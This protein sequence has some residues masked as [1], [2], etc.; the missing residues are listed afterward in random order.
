MKCSW[1]CWFSSPLLSFHRACP[2]ISPRLRL[3]RS[4]LLDPGLLSSRNPVLIKVLDVLPSLLPKLKSPLEAPPEAS[5]LHDPRAG[6]LHGRFCLSGLQAE[7]GREVLSVAWAP[8]VQRVG[9]AARQNQSLPPGAA[10]QGCKLSEGRMA[11]YEQ[12]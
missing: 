9:R 10:V 8:Q 12:Q 11:S 5:A 1:F 3:L 6:R 2:T 4:V 7:E